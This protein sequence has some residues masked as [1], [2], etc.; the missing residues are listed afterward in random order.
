MISLYSISHVFQIEKRRFVVF[1]FYIDLYFLI[2]LGDGFVIKKSMIIFIVISYFSVCCGVVSLGDTQDGQTTFQFSI[3]KAIF[4]SNSGKMWT[5]TDQNLS[6]FSDSIQKFGISYT[7]FIS[8]DGQTT[9]QTLQS[10]PYVTSDAVV[11]T[12]DEDGELDAFV[13]KQANPLYGA[14][15]AD[16]TFI[17]SY[18]TCFLA[19]TPHNIYCLQSAQFSTPLSGLTPEEVSSKVVEMGSEGVSVI[20]KLSLEEGFGAHAISGLSAQFNTSIKLNLLYVAN[21]QGT[22]GTDNSQI[23]LAVMYSDY[24]FY[25]DKLG[26]YNYLTMKADQPI[27]PALPVLTA[28]TNA[29]QSIGSSV[30]ISALPGTD[31]Q[32]LGL[33][34]TANSQENSA[35]V[36]LVCIAPL[37][38]PTQ[39][40]SVDDL[41]FD[42][43][44][45]SV[46][47]DS[48]AT[49]GVD[50]IISTTADQRVAIE[51]VTTATMS[52]QLSYL[53]VARSNGV[54]DQYI[55]AA[56]MVKSTSNMNL[57]NGKI[58]KFDT[59]YQKFD[60]ASRIQYFNTV[61]DDASE[62][63]IAGSSQVIQRLL[64]GGQ[65]VPLVS[66]ESIDQLYVVGD[67]VF[68]SIAT[69]ESIATT[70][71]IF[72]SHALFDEQGRV[73]GWT[74]WQRALGTS[75]PILCVGIQ[76]TSG[77]TMY[78]GGQNLS[79]IYQT[80]WNTNVALHNLTDAIASYL[81]FSKRGVQGLDI[82]GPQ[83]PGLENVALV[84]AAGND[85]AI[86]GQTG[87]VSNQNI[88]VDEDQT[89]FK[90]DQSL[91]LSIG[92]IVTTTFCTD[93]ND[94]Y[95]FF[96]GADKGLAIFSDDQTG[97]TF[98][99]NLVDLA[100]L[101]AD[102]KSC[103]TLGNF[104]FVKKIV[105]NG[106]YL[107]VLTLDGVY[108][109]ELNAD[110]F[111]LD[112]PTA[113]DVQTVVKATDFDI[114][115][116]C[117]DMI[118]TDN[119]M[120]VGT[121]VGLYT[122][123]FTQQ[124]EGVISFVDIPGGYQAVNSIV[125]VV[126]AGASWYDLANVYIISY[127]YSLQ[128][129]ALNRLTIYQG[130]INPIQD[131]ILQN[132]NGPLLNFDLMMNGLC[133]GGAFGFTTNFKAGT[134]PPVMNYLDY[135]LH[136]GISST[137]YL[138]KGNVHILL[139][140]KLLSSK[141]NTT[142][143]LQDY[144]SGVIMVAGDFGLLT[145]S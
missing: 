142:Q 53:F 55:Y 102:G 4:D 67:T 39:A 140:K 45:S 10:Y 107:Y 99:S 103:K 75:D 30:M 2:I 70:P 6:S 40:T 121:T 69:E 14:A 51:K 76:R 129:T 59:I 63:D 144:G 54:D 120:L 65:A 93:G 1:Y 97:I 37:V 73:N 24:A 126:Q 56:P 113:L 139:L 92:S 61:I 101:T 115:A 109:I 46:I 117:L 87:Y 50:T 124:P 60:R 88:L 5:F 86:I 85:T 34:V 9:S 100:S 33:D 13:L 11:A 89:V 58:A 66:G 62:I 90:I 21:S 23:S 137:Q 8:V 122:L 106:S 145:L 74:A 79:N 36:G 133:V 108:K 28:Q 130:Q 25:Q 132:V 31:I 138:L 16:A 44:F 136:A 127:N 29:L 3:G 42:I 48:V 78:V 112:N 116:M 111:V 125:P 17:G 80:T 135:Y 27:I 91:G 94:N 18:L 52:T 118:I 131:Q 15:C 57:N 20:S 12:V 134:I 35:A 71:G 77:A 68:V 47:P 72:T 41:N 84:V 26:V 128:Q 82:F 119:F 96:M 19:Q 81:P 95:F 64:V 143:I 22:F 43:F 105:S 49:Q 98:Q 123:D 141:M 104:S 32:Y 110:K 83:T 7:D 38:T 114:Y